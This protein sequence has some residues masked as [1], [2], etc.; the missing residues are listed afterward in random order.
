MKHRSRR[1]VPIPS[2][3]DDQEAE[4]LAVE[5]IGIEQLR[6]AKALYRAVFADALRDAMIDDSDGALPADEYR[7]REAVAA[8]VTAWEFFFAPY[9]RGTPRVTLE[10]A[11]A[12]LGRSVSDVRAMVRRIATPPRHAMPLGDRHAYLSADREERGW[13]RRRGAT[14]RP[15]GASEG[16]RGSEASA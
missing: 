11:C 3:D 12:V 1:P 15:S 4:R 6:L 7:R 16:E 13:Y 10:D 5:S 9:P 14:G 8:K 2:L